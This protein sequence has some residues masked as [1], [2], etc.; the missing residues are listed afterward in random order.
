MTEF[1]R[2]V[3]ANSGWVASRVEYVKKNEGRNTAIIHVGADLL[4]RKCYRPSDWHHEIMVLDSTGN[5]KTGADATPWTIATMATMP[6]NA[7]SPSRWT[8]PRRSSTRS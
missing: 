5:R 8:R 7:P 3:H 1:G 2:Y 6:A 4:L